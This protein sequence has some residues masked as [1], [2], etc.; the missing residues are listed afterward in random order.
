MMDTAKN[1]CPGETWRRIVVQGW[2]GMM[3]VLLMISRVG[4]AAMSEKE[5]N[6]ARADYRSTIESM[7][8]LI[9]EE[10]EDR[11]VT[12]LSI[13]LIDDQRVVWA[14]G[15]GYAD[16]A[17]KIPAKA[18]TVYRAG[19]IASLFTAT[20]VMQL[21]EQGKIDIDQPLQTCLPEFSVKSRFAA[22]DP[23]T[24]R[25]IMTHHSGLPAELMKGSYAYNPD[26]FEDVVKEIEG[27]YLS[28]PP[29]SVLVDST[30]AM[31]LMGVALERVAG[32]DYASHMEAAIL[33]PLGMA[34][35]SFSQE[36][37]HSP[38]A[39]KAYEKGKEKVEIPL[40]DIPAIGLNSTVLD[41]SRYMAMIFADGRSG[42]NRIIEPG[43]LAEMLHPQN[44]D[45]ALDLDE[46]IGITWNLP[47]TYINNAG[48]V[49]S[50]RGDTLYHRGTLV[51]LPEHKLGVAI[52]ANSAAAGPVVAKMAG[53][54]LQLAL[55]AKANIDQTENRQAKTEVVPI[56]PKI[57]HEYTGRYE[58]KAGLITIAKES[59]S[60]KVELMNISLR[61][62]PRADDLF[63]LQ[64]KL[65]GLIPIGLKE[66]EK[67]G[68]AKD[69][70][71]GRDIIKVYH[72]GQA[73]LFGE[74]I[75]L[76]PIPRQWLARTGDYEA[77]NAGSEVFRFADIHL[78]VDD[79]LLVFEYALPFFNDSKTK[80]PI[81]AVSETE[82]VFYGLGPKK[83]DTIAVVRLDGEELLQ[84]SGYL[85][86]KKQGGA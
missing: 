21:A 52:L 27:S 58:T 24:P 1:P 41:L 72:N 37:D 8:S 77:I 3:F 36:P 19:A 16:E 73:A 45:V 17:N 26:P 79:G 10:M 15:F 34:H 39:S 28:C 56:N 44:S 49:A 29:N 57:L 47:K 60:L 30:L 63:H 80:K 65:L 43:T 33:S 7:T 40:R 4:A 25:A 12:G 38:F 51:V 67:I 18:E 53:K 35:S 2:I 11:D 74:R 9:K 23:I 62:I 54:T 68:F 31:S 22:S 64:F 86:R 46:R 61:L 71:Q 42:E 6:P 13:A 59:D 66:F 75:E 55:K 70:I 85:F 14:E 76:S 84:Y 5:N 20:A 48:L 82:A 32:R 83:G 78:G 50:L 81:K 69:R